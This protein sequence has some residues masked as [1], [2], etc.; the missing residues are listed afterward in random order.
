MT[1]EEE[2]LIEQARARTVSLEQTRLHAE[3]CIVLL[4][5]I[6]DTNVFMPG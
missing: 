2:R 3:H 4:N 1:A 6:L 5:R